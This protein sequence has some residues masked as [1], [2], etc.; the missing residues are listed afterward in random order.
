[1]GAGVY[2]L[3]VDAGVRGYAGMGALLL[4]GST[5]TL[6][7]TLRDDHEANKWLNRVQ[8]ARTERTLHHLDAEPAR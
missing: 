7:K 4:T 6:A 1:M 2:P 8:D 3:P 5:F